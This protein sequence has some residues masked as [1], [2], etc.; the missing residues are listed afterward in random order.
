MSTGTLPTDQVLFDYFHAHR[1]MYGQEPRIHYLGNQWYQLNGEPVHRTVLI[2]EIDRLR[3]LYEIQ[4]P[5]PRGRAA[6]YPRSVIQRIINK[7]RL[8]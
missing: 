7:L 3:G 4:Q 5:A 1:L 8:A 6:S 2:R